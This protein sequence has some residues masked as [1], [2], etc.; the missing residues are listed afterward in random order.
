MSYIPQNNFFKKKIDFSVLS[1][2]LY[3][4]NVAAHVRLEELERILTPLGTLVKCEKVSSAEA[5]EGAEETEIIVTEG[6]DED[7]VDSSLQS[8]SPQTVEVVFE[9]AEEAEK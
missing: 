6:E 3:V 2:T 4:S 8:S 5:E 7:Q 9:T 1:R